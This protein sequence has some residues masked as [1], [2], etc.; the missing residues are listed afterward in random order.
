MANYDELK[1]NIQALYEAAKKELEDLDKKREEVQKTIELLGPIYGA[2]VKNKYTLDNLKNVEAAAAPK[3]RR[4]RKAGRKAAVKAV[5]DNADETKKPRIKE[6]AISDIVFKVLE[7]VY[8]DSLAANEIVD[9][10][11]EAGLPD[12]ASFRTRIYTLLSKWTKENRLLKSGRGVYQI[13]K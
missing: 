10:I 11:K 4:G 3:S 6:S 2:N 5:A 7:D 8:P 1:G 12:S 9:K 13:V